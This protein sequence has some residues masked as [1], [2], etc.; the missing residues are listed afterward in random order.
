MENLGME[1]RYWPNV[2]REKPVYLLFRPRERISKKSMWGRGRRGF[3]NY[4]NLRGKKLHVSST[5]M[6]LMPSRGEEAVM[7]RRPKPNVI[8]R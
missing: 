3:E 6:K 4:L 1:R 2:L 7:A 8:L 5:L